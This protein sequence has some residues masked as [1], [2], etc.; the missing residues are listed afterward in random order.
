MKEQPAEIPIVQTRTLRGG[1]Q[2]AYRAGN[3]VEKL[4]AQA[5]LLLLVPVPCIGQI[6][7]SLQPHVDQPSHGRL[8]NRASTSDQGEP[9]EGLA[10]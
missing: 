1:F 10:V 8:R 9:T 3:L 2:L 4:S 7:L 5:G 6:A